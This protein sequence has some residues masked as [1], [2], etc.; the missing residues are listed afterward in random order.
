MPGLKT[1][2]ALPTHALNDLN[3]YL[4]L[5]HHG[6]ENF[7]PHNQ[8]LPFGPHPHR[9]FETLT[10]IVEGEL[11]HRDSEGFESRI[12]TGGIQWMTAGAGIIHSET[13]SEEFLEKGGR[14]E[15]LQL[16]INLPA[17]S[18]MIPA[19]YQGF[20]AEALP[21]IELVPKVKM[22]LISGA[23]GK[24][25]GPVDSPFPQFMSTI[26]AEAA[27]SF[28]LTSNDNE[29]FFYLVKGRI[30]LNDQTIEA[31]QI[32]VFEPSAGQL[33]LEVLDEAYLIYGQA[34][35]IK[36]P[37]AAQG[38]FVMNTQAELR[39]AFADYQAGKMGRWQ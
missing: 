12:N 19:H 9:G 22:N 6:P 11:V 32:V 31:R 37:I 28:E 1:W 8:G 36:E 35:R 24:Q 27:S 7:P 18:K 5:N 3:P 10:F 20:Q 29:L 13:S 33:Q 16:W 2:R 26:E 4:F 23:F 39:Q 30:K 21:V 25:R 34:P 15:I 14:L 17:S 38:P